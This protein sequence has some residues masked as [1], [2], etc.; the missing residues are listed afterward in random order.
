MGPLG[1]R[2]KPSHNSFIICLIFSSHPY[3]KIETNIKVFKD[4]LVATKV[5]LRDT[6]VL[7]ICH[8]FFQGVQTT[9]SKA[10]K[11]Q[12]HKWRAGCSQRASNKQAG[13]TMFRF[14]PYLGGPGH[15]QNHRRTST[16]LTYAANSQPWWTDRQEGLTSDKSVLC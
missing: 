3:I 11:T 7:P 9:S 14:C 15:L 1:F 6:V 8:C 12:K 10:K 4:I 13:S 16:D 5:L 2:H